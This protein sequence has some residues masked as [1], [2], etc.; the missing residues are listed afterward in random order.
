MLIR[1][2]YSAVEKKAIVDAY[3]AS[4]DVSTIVLLTPRLF[5]PQWANADRVEY[6]EIIQYRHYYRLL[7]EIDQSTLVVINEC[8]RT[9]NR[10]DLTYNCIQNFLLQTKHVIVFQTL[11]LIDQF[12]DFMI[13]LDWATRSKYKRQSFTASMLNEVDL[14]CKALPIAFEPMVVPTDDS[15]KNRYEQV[16]ERLFSNLGTKDPHTL[17]R[18]LYLVGGKA[19][20]AQVQ[21]SQWYL[22]R[23]NRFKLKNLQT[24]S[25]L[26]LP[27]APYVI[28]EL[29]HRFIDMADAIT[30]SGQ[31]RFTVLLAD[32]KV[33]H[34]YFKRYQQWAERIANAFATLYGRN[35]S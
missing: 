23:N 13:L 34:W 30:L 5:D 21:L 6:A 17:P 12:D 31:T 28:F 18:N 32:L 2:G 11:P 26:A 25:A 1:I 19:K 3:I 8:L 27:H 16:K 20:Q 7:R 10:H 35:G 33:D 14:Q 22:G 9:Q 15:L 4:R 29:P 24:Y